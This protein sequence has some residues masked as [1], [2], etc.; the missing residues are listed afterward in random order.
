MGLAYVNF[1]KQNYIEVERGVE[2]MNYQREVAILTD[3]WQQRRLK[4][5]KMKKL[6]EKKSRINLKNQEICAN[7][8]LEKHFQALQN[9]VESISEV[10]IST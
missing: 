7:F 5:T 6:I 2:Y 8:Q 10:D 3:F 1:I 9:T 4:D